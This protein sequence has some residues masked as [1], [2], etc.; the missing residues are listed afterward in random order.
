MMDTMTDAQ[1]PTESRWMTAWSHEEGERR[2]L[3]RLHAAFG[4]ESRT[5]WS[6]PGRVNVVGEYTD[7]SNGLCLST[8][9]PHRTFVAAAKRD[10]SVVRI[11][12]DPE[13]GGGKSPVVWEGDL[14]SL[15]ELSNEDA[16]MTYPAGVLWALQERGYGGCG[17]DL[18][19]VSC[20]PLSSG[21]SS[22]TS[23]TAA[24]ALAANGLWGL[25]LPTGI[26][27]IELAEVC[28]DAENGL[29]GSLTG[30]IAQHTILR[31]TPGEAVHLD[32]ET[33]PPLADA[34]P[35]TF[36][37]YG[38]GL[39]IIDTGVRTSAQVAMVRQRKAEVEAAARALNVSSLRELQSIPEGFARIEAI[40]DA[41]LRKR[42]RH[43]FTENERV[44]LVRDEL[45]SSAPAHERFVTVGKAMYR[46]HASL[47]MDLEVSCDELNVA[48]D[49]A[50]RVGALGARMVGAGGGGSAVA[51][52]RRSQAAAAAKLIDSEFQS[53]GLARPSFAFF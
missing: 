19:V 53:H 2:A 15:D 13:R 27:A 4:V 48:V 7:L 29:V 28:I 30:G 6:A 23:L 20:V 43:I 22:S 50:F 11:T 34:C 16:W 10:D 18:A 3:A 33:T 24:T 17:M 31:C 32:F 51:L 39:L 25:S 41:T 21:L 52:V 45:S 38:L 14:S 46:S 5:V 42:A 9:V 37:E 12:V 1:D 44:D 40:E 49:T 35:L 26:G 47:E 8:V 36:A